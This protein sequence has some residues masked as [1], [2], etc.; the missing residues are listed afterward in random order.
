MQK[1]Y[2]VYRPEVCKHCTLSIVLKYAKTTCCPSSWNIQKN[3]HCSLSWGLQ[4]PYDV[5]R[6][7][8]YLDP[9]LSKVLKCI[10]TVCCPQSWVILDPLQSMVPK[11]VISCAP[12]HPEVYKAVFCLWFQHAW[13]SPLSV[14]LHHPVTVLS[15]IKVT[16]PELY[17]V[18]QKSV[19]N[20][21]SDPEP[22]CSTIYSVCL[23]K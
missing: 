11:N 1:L 16:L 12:L 2:D 9:M 21:A 8:V 22:V 3:I 20:G 10:Y 17:T 4:K 15:N 13:V 6:P 7:E 19:P 23:R 18:P 5:L 14:A